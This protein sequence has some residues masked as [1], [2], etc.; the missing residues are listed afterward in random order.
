MAKEKALADLANNN[1]AELKQAKEQ[2]DYMRGQIEDLREQ[3]TNVKRDHEAGL[4]E[5]ATCSRERKEYAAELDEV[6]AINVKLNGQ[7]E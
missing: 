3:L 1:P 7:N 2:V 5:L 4:I 6:K